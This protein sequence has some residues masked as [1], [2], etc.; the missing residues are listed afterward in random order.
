[1]REQNL[2]A[3]WLDAGTRAGFVA[4]IVT[5]LIY[6]LGLM[7]PHVPPQELARHWGLPVDRYL[8]ATGAPTGWG[9]L[10]FLGKGDYLNFVGIAALASV[11]VFCYARII[12][13]L[14]R[15]QAVLAALQIVVLL[16]AASG[17]VSGH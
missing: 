14:P 11:T 8:E 6:V 2:Y 5:F 7:D 15:V 17:L 3:R 13:V 12:P 1:M 9:W 16:L 10:K 4:L